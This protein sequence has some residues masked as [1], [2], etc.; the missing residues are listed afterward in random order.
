MKAIHSS[1]AFN[2]A[3]LL[4]AVVL[5]LALAAGCGK[6][7][8]P[9]TPE[10]GA[11]RP[12]ADPATQA[13]QAWNAGDHAASEVLNRRLLDRGGLDEAARAKAWERLAVSA[14]N[15]GHGHVAL[16]A[17]RNLA[18]LRPA[19]T[20][21][22]QWQ[23]VYLRA[24]VSIH[25]PQDARRHMD[26][27]LRD[28]ARPWDLRFRAGLSLARDLWGDRNYEQAMRTLGRLYKASPEP[29][30]V[31]R[32]RLE[33]A[34]LEELKLI[35]DPTLTALA[36]IVPPEEQWS[37]PYTIVRLEQARRLAM[38]ETTRPQAWQ[39]INNLKRL[40]SF[41]DADLA[42]EVA[43]PLM[44][45]YGEPAGGLVLALPLTGPYA[46]VGW[47]V[48]RGAGAAQWEGLTQG[49]RTS[50]RV[51]NTEAPDWLD[52]IRALPKGFVLLGG[53]LRQ[54]RFE[55]LAQSGLTGS[56]PTFAFMPRLSGA[57]EGMDA[58]RF[59]PGSQDETRAL[60][61]LA[62]GEL[63]ITE[64]GV[65][66]PDEPYGRHFAEVFAAEVEDWMG[67]VNATAAYPPGEPTKWAASVAPFLGVDP[68]VPEKEREPV[69]PPF[70][71]VFVPD[72]WSQAK[73]LVPQFFFYDED[74][75]LVL[76]PS[77]WGQGLARDEN[78]EA[79]YFRTAVFP[80][81]WWAD[82]PA[83][84]AQALRRTLAADG[85][86]EPDFWIA[87]GYDFV[88]FAGLMPPLPSAWAPD[89][90]NAALAS[91][92]GVEWSMAPLT[93]DS[94]GRVRQAQFLFMPSGK[95]ASILNTDLLK[96]RLERVRL[97]HEERVKA[98]LEK[99]ELDEIMKLQAADPDNEELNMRLQMLQDAIEQRK[100]EQQ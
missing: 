15:N 85:L 62:M 44:E 10:P 67:S 83:P 18:R 38:D 56:H 47:K 25:R 93:W 28:P 49:G 74:R 87:L 100:L 89:D 20:D 39:L 73:L 14:L 94:A 95:G 9:T 75:L 6:K 31:S 46:E 13:E 1:N 50:I 54:D 71:A 55:R 3:L 26:T 59:F 68:A 65:I 99:R 4:A 82:N 35:D 52:R 64:F 2:R 27:L 70:S 36:S 91:T 12:V 11:G 57:V 86:G 48:L 98:L 78:V 37:F 41:A 69:A 7:P 80:G 79:N 51:V 96:R 22:W 32:A 53:P 58:W 8:V 23:D 34:F 29:A 84:G 76:G 88:R 40:G 60:V 5:L 16:E 21:T 24:L 72:G 81:P 90:V 45:A 33:R 61:G 66:H 43:A 19:A 30:P 92:Q 77:L 97:A 17:L 42:A 63:G